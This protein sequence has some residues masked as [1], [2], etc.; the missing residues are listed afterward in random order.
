MLTMSC[1]VFWSHVV[2]S[3]THD[4]VQILFNGCGGRGLV[5]E[6]GGCERSGSFCVL[7][8]YE[9]GRIECVMM[10]SL[11]HSGG[12]ALVLLLW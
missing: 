2:A 4:G 5:R 9:M 6:D 3:F 11:Q 7:E 10:A 8:C 1:S 12:V